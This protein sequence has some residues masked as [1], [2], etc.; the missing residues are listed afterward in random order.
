MKIA[1]FRALPVENCRLNLVLAARIK[2]SVRSHEE[3]NLIFEAW[4]VVS[5]KISPEI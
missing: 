4:Q 5:G 2:K 1:F 3:L